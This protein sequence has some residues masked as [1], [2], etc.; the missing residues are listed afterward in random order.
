MALVMILLAMNFAFWQSGSAR[1]DLTVL[2]LKHAMETSVDGACRNVSYMDEED[3]AAVGNG[4]S[5]DASVAHGLKIDVVEAEKDFLAL[6]E[7]GRIPKAKIRLMVVV[8]P[9][10]LYLKEQGGAWSNKHPFDN[11][12]G[13]N[14]YR[15]CLNG[16]VLRYT[17]G[18][19]MSI[20]EF[21]AMSMEEIVEQ[22]NWCILS[23]INDSLK[24]AD[25]A[26]P[27]KRGLRF[28]SGVGPLKNTYARFQGAGFLAVLD[29]YEIPGM[30]ISG[31]G[32]SE[33]GALS[34][35]SV[36]GSDLSH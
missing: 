35:Y 25:A 16:D 9:D 27:N 22:I 20:E 12:V 31:T 13:G 36:A 7:K 17:D 33:R 34:V 14:S 28:F 18:K 30:G 10:G 23:R 26:T 19:W 29:G 3:L 1:Q 21:S 15:L 5:E 6:L 24:V 4:F 11:L 32:N 8:A 2:K